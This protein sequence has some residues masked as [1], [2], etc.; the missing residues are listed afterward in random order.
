LATPPGVRGR[1]PRER[2]REAGVRVVLP[3]GHGQGPVQLGATDAG[4]G[5]RVDARVRGAA[6]QVRVPGAAARVDGDSL[7]ADNGDRD[8]AD[9]GRVRADA[10][11]RGGQAG[12]GRAE[13]SGRRLRGHRAA[14]RRQRLHQEKTAEIFI[15]KKV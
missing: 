4:A 13:E 9:G 10:V 11:R 12:G 5:E 8:A 2:E 15:P 7:R 1:D 6:R 3:R 14:V